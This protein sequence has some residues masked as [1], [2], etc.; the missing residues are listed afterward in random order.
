M[1]SKV[2]TLAP[3]LLLFSIFTGLSCDADK[4]SGSSDQANTS[5]RAADNF[6]PSWSPDGAQ[7]AFHSDRDGNNQ[8]YV[9]N[10]DGTNPTN[11]SNNDDSD[12]SP[13]WSLDGSRIGFA[14]SRNI[15][16]VDPQIYTMNADGTNQAEIA[17]DSNFG[18]PSADAQNFEPAWSPVVYVGIDPDDPEAPEPEQDRS[19]ES[20]K[21]AF[22]SLGRQ[23]GERISIYE[24][25]IYP[26][27]PSK[28]SRTLTQIA[29]T[30]PDAAGRDVAPSWS[31][32][33]TRIAF[34]SNG[35]NFPAYPNPDRD[36]E[37]WVMNAD[38]TNPTRLTDNT[39][40]DRSPAWSPDGTQ[41]A[42]V[43][44][45]D[46]DDFIQAIYVMNAIDGTGQTMITSDVVYQAAPAWSPDGTLIAFVS[47]RDGTNEI[48]RMNANGTDQ[49][50]LTNSA[51]SDGDP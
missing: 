12:K 34:A 27:K 15:V 1:K 42:F 47:G 20:N 39:A 23:G 26:S 44:G 38:G 28:T 43:S 5:N 49:T 31:P 32:D 11:I 46:Q 2:S 3:A 25:K 48:Y 41:I 37:I 13:S 29:L 6:A 24:E 14:S 22:S 4:D 35:H 33:G 50:R 16:I 10:A 36:F 21:I 17:Y 40:Y 19:F 7:I 9:M 18:D 30:P 45:P 8:I 51:G